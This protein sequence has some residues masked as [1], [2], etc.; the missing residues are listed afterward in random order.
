MVVMYVKL[1]LRSSKPTR[2]V[3]RRYEWSALSDPDV[4]S[5]F[6][7]CCA[8]LFAE[9]A[10]SS[11][12]H[13][14]NYTSFVDSVAT[15][16]EE[17]IPPV[18]QTKKRVPW[19]DSAVKS[20]RAHLAS[21]KAAHRW[22][23]TY[24]TPD[25]IDAASAALARQYSTSQ[26][27]YIEG[28]LEN[29]QAADESRKPSEVWKTI[30]NLSGRK[31]K[32]SVK[33]KANSP[34]DRLA[35]WKTHFENLLNN[36]TTHSDNFAIKRIFP[37]DGDILHDIPIGDITM[38]EVLI[39]SRQIKPKPGQPQINSRGYGKHQIFVKISSGKFSGPPWNLF[40]CMVRNA[41]HWP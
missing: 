27:R 31:S 7:I 15:A 13:K 36:K 3:H 33:I 30:N 26:M 38:E 4:L 16:A 1:S 24:A 6:R 29:I 23:R 17:C 18:V 21:A 9:L 41:G 11:S 2:L 34:A 25:A 8:N 5:R 20:A 40:S 14:E 35:G 19:E 32:A 22:Y 37:G 10:T 28:Q 12:D 39:A